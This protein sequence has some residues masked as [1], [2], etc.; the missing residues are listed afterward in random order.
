MTLTLMD[1]TEK[2]PLR[3]DEHGVIRVGKTRVTLDLVVETFKEGFTPEE[4]IQQ[5]PSLDLSD[6]YYVVGYYLQHT[7][8]VEAYL[9]QGELEHQ[10]VREQNESQFQRTG[11]RERLLARQKYRKAQ[12]S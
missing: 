9:R 7:E 12:I 8:L 11:I 10:R 5:Y 1:V 6:V 2:I 4:I 3:T